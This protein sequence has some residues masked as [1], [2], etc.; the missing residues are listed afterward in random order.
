MTPRFWTWALLLLAAQPGCRAAGNVELLERELRWQED[1]I[2]ELEKVVDEY[3]QQ[4][5]SCQ[6]ENKSLLS[7]D[8]DAALPRREAAGSRDAAPRRREPAFDEDA[9]APPEVILPG[10]DQ[11]DPFQPPEIMPPGTGPEGRHSPADGARPSQSRLDHDPGADQTPLDSAIVAGITLN[12]RLTGGHNVDGR[13]GD[14]GV[15]VVI[16]PRDAD[17]DLV[18]VAGDV[19]VVVLDPARQGQAARVARWDFT[20]HEAAGHLRETPMGNGL[21]FELRWPHGPP[22]GAALTLYVR[23]TTSDGRKLGVEK[24]ID[25]DPPGVPSDQ[26]PRSAAAPWASGPERAESLPRIRATGPRS[27]DADHPPAATRSGPNWSPYR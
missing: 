3:T 12:P 15:M 22:A 17:G 16:E 9:L 11:A 26:W 13:A 24:Q 7:D 23:F 21:H 27:I 14:E 20:A 8:E 6:R 2:Y 19:S 5:E 25:V 1:R 18:E 4:L 10:D